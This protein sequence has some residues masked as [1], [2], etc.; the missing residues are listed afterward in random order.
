MLRIETLSTLQHPV[1]IMAVARSN[2]SPTSDVLVPVMEKQRFQ[3]PVA[4]LGMEI[5][6]NVHTALQAIC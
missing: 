5:K 6:N 4:V 2:P 3:T 1:Y